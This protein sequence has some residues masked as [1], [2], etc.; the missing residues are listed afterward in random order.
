MGQM[1]YD[2]VVS[3]ENMMKSSGVIKPPCNR[4]IYEGDAGSEKSDFCFVCGSSIKRKWE[5][6]WFL[7]WKTDKC[8][9]PECSNYWGG[10]GCPK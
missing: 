3:R 5:F 2:D 4:L 7:I 8:I 9:Q 6:G 1:D 10:K